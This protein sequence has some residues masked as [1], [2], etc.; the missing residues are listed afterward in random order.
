MYYIISIL[1][2]FATNL[3]K[4]LYVYYTQKQNY[5]LLYI[6]SKQKNR[7]FAQL[8]TKMANLLTQR[9]TMSQHNEGHRERLRERM[10]KEGLGS[11]QD[12]E[13]LELLL[14]QYIPRKDTNKIAHALLDQFGSIYNIL[15][16]PPEQLMTVD[17]V[18][19]MTACNLSMLKEVLQ[20]YI[21]GQSS[22]KKFAGVQ[23][24]IDYA[25]LLISNCYV[26]QL[27]FVFVDNTTTYLHH[28]IYTSNDT[29][30]VT[31]DVKKIVATAV[32]VGAT[33][34]V[35]SHC[36]EAVP[37]SC[38]T[39][40]GAEMPQAK[41]TSCIY[42]CRVASVVSDSLQSYRLWPARLLCQGEGFSRQEYWSV[43]ANTGCHTLLEHYI[44]CCPG[45]Q[46]P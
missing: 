16:A 26:E 23:S 2:F 9:I 44:S 4:N 37:P 7:R 27:V 42:V 32:R 30:R 28:E 36:Q 35:V 31:I 21:R 25:K 6:G 8:V 45:C 15:N 5:V 18:S 39:L 24:M 38:S 13:V 33:G 1:Q 12:H 14:F 29:Q 3:R 34:V 20:R 46:L 19:K 41:K 43:L 22:R 11:F 40:T 10:L 17:G